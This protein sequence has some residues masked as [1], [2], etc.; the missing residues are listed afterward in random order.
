MRKPDQLRAWLLLSVADLVD[1]P[2]RL[3]LWIENGR[4][5][6]IP[7]N[8]L[9]YEY[10]YE[11]I[12][13]VEDFSSPAHNLVVPI[14]AWLSDNQPDLLRDRSEDGLPINHDILGNSSANIEIKLAL[15]ERAIVNQTPAGGWQVEYPPEPAFPESFAGDP[16][17]NLARLYLNNPPRDLSF[18]VGTVEQPG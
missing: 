6:S 2:D 17:V 9:S 12:V 11:L 3:H 8:T 7:G 13:V 16:R 10:R 1:Q 15:K 18:L 4:L 14:L 5:R